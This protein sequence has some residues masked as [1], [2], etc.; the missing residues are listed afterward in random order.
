MR[1]KNERG[2]HSNGS[3]FQAGIGKEAD[4]YG[5]DGFDIDGFNPNGF[6]ADGIHRDTSTEYGLDGK[7]K[8]GRLQ[9]DLQI[10]KEIM[11]LLK[12]GKV[13]AAELPRR[14][15]KSP[16]EVDRVI[17]NAYSISRTIDGIAKLKSKD[18]NAGK[19][20]IGLI[21]M[22]KENP[23]TVDELFKLSPSMRKQAERALLDNRRMNK[24]YSDRVGTIM[25]AMQKQQNVM[26]AGE[27]AELTELAQK[28]DANVGSVEYRRPED[29]DF[30]L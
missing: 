22:T 5:Y 3:I 15:G 11:S 6:N 30:V 7:D 4:R 24:Y 9:L 28:L 1:F 21:S 13:K 26:K 27:Q 25:A 8:S 12:S 18:P 2:L 14:L 10:T 16:E 19:D 20:V 17:G 29:D 23:K